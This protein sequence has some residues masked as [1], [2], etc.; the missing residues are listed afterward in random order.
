MLMISRMNWTNSVIQTH[1]FAIE[2]LAEPSSRNMVKWAMS[3]PER[4]RPELTRPTLTANA[5]ATFA[6]LAQSLRD[7]G[8][9]PEP[10]A[11]F[12]NRLVFCVFAEDAGLL[13][14]DMFT[15]MLEQSRRSPGE[16]EDM[17]RSLFAAMCSGGRVGFDSVPWFNGGLF[18][19]DA[20]LPMDREQ[21]DIAYRAASLDWSE[22]DPSTL[23]TLFERGLDPE[24]A[25]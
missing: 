25:P 16:S 21:I 4:L 12:V 24:G 8:Q 17:A 7:R 1:E 20:T 11:H 2:D 19:G 15:K 22:I 10:V 9:E 13:P 5:A 3:D 14:N 23:G 18:H 6:E